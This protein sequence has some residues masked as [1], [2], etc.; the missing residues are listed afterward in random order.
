[1]TDPWRTYELTADDLTLK[2][3]PG[4]G[5]RLWDVVY[6]GH[7]L[8]FQN[9][10]LIGI[11]PDCNDLRRLP[12]RSP[13][14]GFPLWGGEK[15]WIA[16]DTS[17]HNQAPFPTLDSGAHA[18]I[19][20]DQNQIRTR[21]AICPLSGIQ[22]ER[23]I[24]L[25]SPLGWTVEHA[26]T[27]RG[28]EPRAAGIWS[29]MM[30]NRPVCIG[31]DRGNNDTEF[32]T[33]FGDPEDC[34]SIKGSLLLHACRKPVEFKTGTHN[35]NNTVL[36]RFGSELG[37]INMACFTPPHATTDRFAHGHDFEVF[38]SRDYSYCEAEW[39]SPE[40]FLA[41]GCSAT[42]RQDFCIWSSNERPETMKFT[43]SE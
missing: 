33:V 35:P 19:S 32:V 38:N 11:V 41:A 28:L 36:M 17:W 13:Q 25:N 39:H 3:L 18:I 15:T 22:I 40:R 37:N 4:I 26:I 23:C 14:F 16:P 9:P 42:F 31:V 8:L 1:M 2:C 5:G 7:S 27:N 30:F 29:V 43:E 21:S 24:S 20:S 34:V 12:T 6:R 10:D